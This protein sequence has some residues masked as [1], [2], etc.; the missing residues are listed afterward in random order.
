[1][2]VPRIVCAVAAGPDLNI[3]TPYAKA[4]NSEPP[5]AAFT[6]IIK[7]GNVNM[8]PVYLMCMDVLKKQYFIWSFQNNTEVCKYFIVISSTF[9]SSDFC[10]LGHGLGCPYGKSGPAVCRFIQDC[11]NTP[12]AMDH[13]QDQTA[14]RFLW[15]VLLLLLQDNFQLKKSCGRYWTVYQTSSEGRIKQLSLTCLLLF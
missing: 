10:A 5:P 4:L 12:K 6:A 8:P 1:M 11:Q 13:G 3:F 14:R 2:R 7:I 15:D 9:A